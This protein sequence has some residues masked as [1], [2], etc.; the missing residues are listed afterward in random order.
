MACAAPPSPNMRLIGS[1]RPSSYMISLAIEG[2]LLG[3]VNAIHGDVKKDWYI[4]L[5]STN[6]KP[7]RARDTLYIPT[8]EAIPDISL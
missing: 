6:G 7:S 3:A 2:S 8:S 5:S 4:L 1:F